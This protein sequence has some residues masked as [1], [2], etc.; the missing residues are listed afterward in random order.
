VAE[1]PFQGTPGK[2]P[3]KKL[4][5]RKENLKKLKRREI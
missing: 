4:Q 3:V 5:N 1:S 2:T